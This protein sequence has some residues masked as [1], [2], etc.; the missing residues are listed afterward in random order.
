MNVP[1]LLVVTPLDSGGL[2]GPKCLVN[3]QNVALFAPSPGGNYTAL[4]LVNGR[5]LQVH[6]KI[7]ELVPDFANVVAPPPVDPPGQLSLPLADNP[8]PPVVGC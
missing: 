7:T 6:E 5:S 3:V 4:L 2:P 8:P 1:T